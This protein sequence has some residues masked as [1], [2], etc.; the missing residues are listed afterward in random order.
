MT[1]RVLWGGS[2]LN[3]PDILHVAYR[4]G[5][6]PGDN[7]DSVGFRC[8]SRSGASRILRGGCWINGPEDLRVVRRII[9]DL[10]DRR[11]GVGFRCVGRG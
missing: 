2:W 10:D 11:D 9:S 1:N 6:D 4:C 8:V 5:Y 7:Y 3:G